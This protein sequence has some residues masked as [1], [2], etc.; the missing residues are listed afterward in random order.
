MHGIQI[1][2]ENKI[3]GKN[4]KFTRR[5]S[6]KLGTIMIVKTLASWKAF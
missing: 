6:R 2:L 5:E 1:Y 4:S 3:C